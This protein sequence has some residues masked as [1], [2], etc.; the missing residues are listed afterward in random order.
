MVGEPILSGLL[1]ECKECKNT[2][3]SCVLS[4]SMTRDATKSEQFDPPSPTSID[5]F[6]VGIH[7]QTPGFGVV[8]RTFEQSDPAKSNKGLSVV[9]L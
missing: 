5:Q 7:G 3:G 4:A 2:R 1:K 8:A 9:V 6:L